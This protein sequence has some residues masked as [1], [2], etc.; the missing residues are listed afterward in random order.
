MVGQSIKM[1][2]PLFRQLD[3]T[4]RESLSRP[5]MLPQN[6]SRN[7]PLNHFVRGP[8]RH[9]WVR[10]PFGPVRETKISRPHYLES[11]P[12]NCR[13]GNNWWSK[14]R[15]GPP[16]IEGRLFCPS[17]STKNGCDSRDHSR[18]LAWIQVNYGLQV[19]LSPSYFFLLLPPI[20]LLV[21]HT[22]DVSFRH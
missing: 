13:N 10:C 16:N 6:T 1:N 2:K 5:G 8:S 22:P 18:V 9:G 3:R 11:R 19:G 4:V 14:L 12:P 15:V 17:L 20:L 21:T 7:T